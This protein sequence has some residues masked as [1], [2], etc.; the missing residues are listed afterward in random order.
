M[1][2]TLFKE[3]VEQKKAVDTRIKSIDWLARKEFYLRQV[4]MLFKTVEE[5]LREFIESGDVQ[6]ETTLEKIEEDNLGEYL[7]PVLQIRLYGKQATLEPGGTNLI[8]TPGRVDLAGNFDSKRLVLAEK[9]ESRPQAGVALP[10]SWMDE[11]EQD[12]SA[13]QDLCPACGY[14]WKFITD[15]PKVRYIELTEDS[16]LSALQEV[17]DA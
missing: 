14:A 5:Y 2:K 12:E 16:F 17:L 4:E 6:I 1:S 8:G 3:F 10:C 11:D 15:P 13:S 7:V 9:D